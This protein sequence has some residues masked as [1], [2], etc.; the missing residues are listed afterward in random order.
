VRFDI[1]LENEATVN[2][3]RNA[4]VLAAHR[5]LQI[6]VGQADNSTAGSNSTAGATNSSTSSNT[7]SSGNSNS[8]GSVMPTSPAAVLPVSPMPPPVQ[9]SLEQKKANL[10]AFRR[11]MCILGCRLRC[12]DI[13]QDDEVPKPDTK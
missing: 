2:A 4:R 6:R 9:L 8:T 11:S 7:T 12:P 5:F 1:G 3:E 10:F 13:N